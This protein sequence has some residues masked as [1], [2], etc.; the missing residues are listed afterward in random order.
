M[1]L[2]QRNIPLFIVFRVLFNARFYY[3]VLGILFL[4]FGLTI[5]QFALLNVAWAIS[6][7]CLEVPSGALADQIGR[8]RMLALAGLLMVIEMCL[9][10]F[11][12]RGS[13][14]LLFAIF[15][16]NR[17]L[18]GAAEASA[19][20]ADEA[21]AYDSLAQDGRAHEWP[22]V[23]ERLMRW[24]SGAF[25]LAMMVGAA[26]YD[27]AL[28][29]RVSDLAG[30]SVRLDRSVT[31][32]FPVYLTLGGAVLVFLAALRMHEPLRAAHEPRTA[33]AGS[34]F[35]Q[36]IGSGRWILRTPFVLVVILCGLCFDSIV[37]LFL[38]VSSNYYRLI[39][40]PEASYGL[41]GSGFALLGF[42]T[43]RL[44][45]VLAQRQSPA[46]N[47][48]LVAS[49]AWLGLL[50]VAAAAPLYGLVF[51]VPLGVAMS[52][53]NFFLSHYLNL[54][55]DSAQR[56][57]VLSFRG[58]ALNLAYG[59]VGLLFAALN[60]ALRASDGANAAPGVDVVFAKSLLW[61]PW[62]FL[63]TVVLL[64]AAGVLLLRND[65]SFHTPV[66]TPSSVA[67][68]RTQ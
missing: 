65:R 56:A 21:L 18:S 46:R 63:G 53:L 66:T 45:R 12:P 62:Y 3:P 26:V 67:N 52:L 7:V 39:Q 47:F 55:V 23:L 51:I 16:F 31:L 59:G 57:T 14:T 22:H 43:A 27:P 68:T 25:F 64:A 9:L 10:A 49:L 20:G 15:L 32:R 54:V 58:L 8:K 38:T 37:R 24:Q 30:L 50:G 33:S 36:I 19:S 34:T 61:L 11:V 2:S 42:V 17:I 35:S 60:R 1:S 5:E 48:A 13:P 40:L 44:A 28:M 6:I 29:Q 41:I 4:D